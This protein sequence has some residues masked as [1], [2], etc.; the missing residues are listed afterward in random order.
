MWKCALV[1][2]DPLTTHVGTHHPVGHGS[3]FRPQRSLVVLAGEVGGRWS[4]ETNTFAQLLA[5]AKARAESLV[6]RR[7]AGQ[8]WRLSWSA[9]LAYAKARAL[10]ASL[11]DLRPSGVDGQVPPSHEVLQEFRRAGLVA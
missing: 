11:S 6:P 1:A 10:A 9:L 5:E 3:V 8:A 4:D 2:R 7:R